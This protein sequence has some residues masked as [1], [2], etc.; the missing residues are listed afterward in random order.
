MEAEYSPAG[1]EAILLATIRSRNMTV[2]RRSSRGGEDGCFEP[3]I[4]EADVHGGIMIDQQTVG[5]S[6]PLRRITTM[7]ARLLVRSSN[8][9]L[10]ASE[11]HT[12]TEFSHEKSRVV[13]SS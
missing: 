10:S 11:Q 6:P 2:H 8:T 1:P 4:T 5:Q 3:R 13:E 12:K 9:S 7:S